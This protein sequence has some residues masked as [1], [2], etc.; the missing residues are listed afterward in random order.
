MAEY[1]GLDA[2]G[3]I[4]VNDIVANS[5]ADKAGLEVADIIYAINGQSVVVDKE[6][7]LPIFQRMIAEMGPDADVQMS[8]IRRGQAGVDTLEILSTLEKAPLAATEAPTYE[9][10]SLEFEVRE[11]VFADYLFH[12]QE[13]ENFTGVVVSSLKRGGLANIAGLQIGDVIQ[14]IGT[15]TIGSIDDVKTIMTTIEE[16]HP[17]EVVFFVWRD[18]KTLFVNVKTDWAQNN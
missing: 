9:V 2:E 3:G 15:T 16:S 13:P 8:V 17:R 18:N 11:L 12:N 10:K 1:W 14:R 6:E 7:K 4:I 5:P